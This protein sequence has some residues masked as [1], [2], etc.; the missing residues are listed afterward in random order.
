V[1]IEIETVMMEDGVAGIA[2]DRRSNL[3]RDLAATLAAGR[4]LVVWRPW[5]LLALLLDMR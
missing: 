1:V 5:L 2:R 3:D 4:S